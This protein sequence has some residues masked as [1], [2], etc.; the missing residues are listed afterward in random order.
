[1]ARTRCAALRVDRIRNATQLAGRAQDIPEAELNEYFASAY[2][3]FSGKAT[4]EAVLHFTAERARWVADERWHPQQHGQFLTDGRY[5]LRVPYRDA[6]ELVMDILRHGA[7]VEV[8]APESLREEMAKQLERALGQYPGR[9]AAEVTAAG[10]G[11]YS[12]PMTQFEEIFAAL[13]ADVRYVVVGGVAVNLH[14][15]QRFTKDLDLV[16]ELIPENTRRALQALQ[17]LGYKPN[18]PVKAADFS[19]PQLR[20]SWIRDKG[21]MVFQ[22]YSDHSRVTVD[23]FVE[24]PLPFDTLWSEAT[25]VELPGSTVRIASIDHL[26]QMKRA[27]SRPQDL[28]DMEKLALI[29][30]LRNSATDNP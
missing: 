26:T 15:Y 4:R 10:R 16:V 18:I 9:D 22:M 13:R 20:A 6:R 5:E 1:M 17:S 14:G 28:L 7:Q 29:R 19:D 3:I 27:A 11:S 12:P 25:T 30:E 8:A 24:H 21:M 23:I 2:G